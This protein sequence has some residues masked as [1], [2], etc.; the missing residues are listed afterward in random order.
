ML[1]RFDLIVFDWDGTLVD[2]TA[3]IARCIQR[4]AADLGLRVPDFDT[5]SHVIG[6][7]L[8]QALARAVPDLPAERMLEFSAR[9]RVHYLAREHELRMFAGARELIEAL[10][11]LDARLAIATGKSREGLARALQAAGLAGA[12]DA[13]R[14]ADETHPKPHPAMLLE[15]ADELGVDVDRTLMI[16][17]TTHDLRMAR[18]ARTHAAGVTYGAH[19]RELLAA[20]EPLALVGSVEELRRW[21]IPG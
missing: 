15:L 1:Q 10:R 19:P 17:D 18:A 14:C 13:T 21:L 12:F 20:C 4:A 5:A 3:T 11:A 9:Y 16:G 7:G 2:S 6:L 8:Q